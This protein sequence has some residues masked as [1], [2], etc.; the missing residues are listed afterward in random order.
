MNKIFLAIYFILSAL[1]IYYLLLP[2]PDF[3]KPPTDAVQSQEP[4]D[5]ETPL[6]RAYFTDFT[7]EEVISS[8]KVQFDGK[9]PTL[10]LNYPP[11]DAQTLIRDQTR[12][13]FLE[14][15]VHPLRESVYINGF[16]PKDPKDTININGRHWRQK[17]IVR[18]VSS[19][20]WIRILIALPT[21]ALIWVSLRSW[22]KEI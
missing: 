18:Y 15:L 1:F 22:R 4:A 9:F 20:D 17:I 13:T 12:S 5:T 8:Y 3:P 21:L 11:E 10:R 6:R 2:T 7:R 19:S 16:E 14:E